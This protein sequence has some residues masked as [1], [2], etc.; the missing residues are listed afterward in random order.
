MSGANINCPSP[1]KAAKPIR[2]WARITRLVCRYL[3]GG[4]FLMAAVT[5]LINLREFESQVLLQSHLPQIVAKIVPVPDVQLSFSLSRIVIALLPWL[6]LTSGLCLLF[7]WAVRESAAIISALL[8]L[9]IVHA[10][11][12][13]GEGCHCFFFPTPISNTPWW[14][15]PLRDGL[16]LG[17]SVYLILLTPSQKPISQIR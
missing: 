5:K 14:W 7:G 13:R 15:H 2:P 4:V 6:E 16:L 11:T 3:V 10:M 8:S 9:F 12:Y 17:C 1:D